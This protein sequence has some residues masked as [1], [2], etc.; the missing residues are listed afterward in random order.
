MFG[1][2]RSFHLFVELTLGGVF[3][4]SLSELIFFGFFVASLSKLIFVGDQNKDGG[5]DAQIIEHSGLYTEAFW[6]LYKFLQ[7]TVYILKAKQHHRSKTMSLFFV[8]SR[9]QYYFQFKDNFIPV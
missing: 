3:V 8:T 5:S 7:I 1:F 2:L 6:V 4:F 9:H